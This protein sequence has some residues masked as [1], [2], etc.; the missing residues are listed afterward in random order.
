MSQR[1]FGFLHASDFR[2]D[3]V[4]HG[5]T[6][7]PDHLR[8]TLLDA[9]YH[10]A[11]QVFDAA[12]TQRV[13]FVIL[14]GNI[15]RPDLT[16][17]RGPAFLSE[18]FQRLAEAGI[19]VYWAGGESDPPEAW[20]VAFPLPENVR[21]FAKDRVSDFLH[22]YDGSPLARIVGTSR[23]S[24]A[25]QPAEFSPDAVGLFSIGV[26]CL[27]A[28]MACSAAES[29]DVRSKGDGLEA[30]PTGAAGGEMETAVL[31]SQGIHYWALG[32][33]AERS[34]LF[35]SPGIAHYPGTP[36]GRDPAE[37]GAHGCTL[38]HV[39][40]QGRAR[41]TFIAANAMEWLRE[42]VLIDSST[43]REGLEA[44]L[45]QRIQSLTAESK[46]DRLVT[47]TIGGSGPLAAE[48]RRGKLRGEL[49]E[50]LRIEH[51]LTSPIVW[52]VGIELEAQNALPPS[53]YEQETILGDFLRA[54]REF[55]LDPR[56][57]LN[58]ES[59]LADGQAAGLPSQAV[60]IAD[61]AARKRVLHEAALLAVE[62]LGGA[63]GNTQGGADGHPAPQNHRL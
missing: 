55:E 30:R 56:Q 42:T 35:N 38:V 31:Q 22:Q 6:E 49:L 50:W 57:P 54:L 13:A 45:A 26:A 60:A 27:P 2:L 19:S 5:L 10:A 8:D 39:D 17:P 1:S 44:M 37:S 52:T 48:L 20:P 11:R 33:R 25:L 61:G 3:A 63:T 41:M 28:D 16:G 43:R 7:V 40:D 24:R 53:L 21:V 4:P 9:P 51:G 32:G 59:L 34:T 12:L 14:A 29:D 46:T 36:Q 18:Q 58:L 15:L 62:L 23:G 47:W